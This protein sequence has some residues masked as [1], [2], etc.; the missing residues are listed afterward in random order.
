[1]RAEERPEGHI[2]DGGWEGH[3]CPLPAPA[4]VA[5][6]PAGGGQGCVVRAAL[7]PAILGSCCQ[8]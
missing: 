2:C 5:T 8:K 3:S 7:P 6:I 1:M 4:P